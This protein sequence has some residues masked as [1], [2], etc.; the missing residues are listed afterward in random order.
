MKPAVEITGNS[1]YEAG[2]QIKTFGQIIWSGGASFIGMQNETKIHDDRNYQAAGRWIPVGC[3][4]D[5]EI[6][7]PQ[8]EQNGLQEV[9]VQ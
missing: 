8:Y 5:R 3:K 1:E 2:I 9:F 4:T 7:F 6:A